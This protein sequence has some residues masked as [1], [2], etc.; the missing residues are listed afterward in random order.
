MKRLSGEPYLLFAWLLVIGLLA[1][2][3]KSKAQASGHL[4]NCTLSGP[5]TISLGLSA[6]PDGIY[7]ND[8]V[9]L[10]WDVRYRDGRPWDQEISFRTEPPLM[11]ANIGSIS[12][13]ERTRQTEGSLTFRAHWQG[14]GIIRLETHCGGSLYAREIAYSP[15]EAPNLDT[16]SVTRAGERERVIIRGRALGSSGEV[17]LVVGGATAAM[18]VQSWSDTAIEVSVPERAAVGAGYIQIFK[19]RGRAQSNSINFRVVKLLV[20]DRRRLQFAHDLLGVSRIQV[21]L[22]DGG[23]FIRFPQEMKSRGAADSSFTV[24]R[25]EVRPSDVGRAIETLL[26]PVRVEQL[27]YSVNDINL[28]GIALSISGGQLVIRISFESN[29][30]EVKGKAYVCTTLPPLPCIDRSWDDSLAPDIE[31][32]DIVITLR[33]TPSVSGGAVQFGSATATFEGS[34]RINNQLINTLARQF[35]DYENRIKSAANDALVSAMGGFSSALS[36]AI[37]AELR[38]SPGLAVN[39]ILSV[40]PSATGDSLRVEYE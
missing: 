17:Q 26:S 18:R 11:R 14:R 23:S 22:D 8:E 33:L 27:R 29:G 24:P 7:R 28:S 10:H 16:L 31:A 2:P 37:M 15:V 30:A 4:R 40:T 35:G 25:L 21:H 32:N 3:I 36:N 39:R 5:P 12:I 38:K 34:F 1:C 20:V 13:P 19:G 6:P 9:T